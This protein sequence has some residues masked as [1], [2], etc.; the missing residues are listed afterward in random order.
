MS[1]RKALLIIFGV[2][3]AGLAGCVVVVEAFG[4]KGGETSSSRSSTTRS[5]APSAAIPRISPIPLTTPPGALPPTGNR[6]QEA[7]SRIVEIINAAFI[8]GE[9]IENTQSIDG[10]RGITYVGGD[11]TS[12]DGKRIS[13]RDTWAVSGG[14]V[15]AI[16][17]DA[18]RRTL[19]P[20]GRDLDPFDW[21][22]YNDELADCVARVDALAPG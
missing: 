8:N 2:L 21:P 11:I 3:F 18:R 6:C 4:P 5:S 19:L 20:D 10:P 7:P 15:Y 9:H 17:S 22:Q 1:N 13:S 16:T 14:A 12:A